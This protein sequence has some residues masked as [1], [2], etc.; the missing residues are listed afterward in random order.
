MPQLPD[1][2]IFKYCK[3]CTH[4]TRRVDTSLHCCLQGKTPNVGHC[5]LHNQKK[6]K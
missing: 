3:G 6:T 5:K 1:T 2:K 4:L